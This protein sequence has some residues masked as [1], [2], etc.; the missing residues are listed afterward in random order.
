MRE[1]FARPRFGAATP[2]ARHRP[3]LPAWLDR[4]LARATSPAPEQRP[5]DALELAQELEHGLARGAPLKVG[6]R[7]LYERNPLLAWKLVSA[8][9]ALLLLASLT[10]R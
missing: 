5:A 8:V 6:R 3:D 9:L 4:A 10:L 1:P 2:L 7:P